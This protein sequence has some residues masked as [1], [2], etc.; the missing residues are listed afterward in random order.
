[1]LVLTAE[2]PPITSEAFYAPF[3]SYGRAADVV[4]S[5]F[6]EAGYD[7]RIEFHS[8][9]DDAYTDAKDEKADAAFPYYRTDWRE[10]DMVF[11][12][13]LLE[14][15]EVIFYNKRRAP[16]LDQ[17]DS[18]Q[19]LK[20]V[21]EEHHRHFRRSARFVEGYCY[22][23]DIAAAFGR[24]CKT[25]TEDPDPRDL[26]P[27]V[28]AF[29]ALLDDQN[30]LMLPA[31]RE[32]G[33]RILQTWF[34]AEARERIEVIPGLQ[35]R[36]PVYLVARDG[37]AGEKLIDGFNRGLERLRLSGQ[38]RELAN[39]PLPE[40][41]VLR[42]VRLSDPGTFPLVVARKEKG[43]AETI[44]LPRGTLAEVVQWS[45]NFLIPERTTLQEQL[46]R[47][48]RVMIMNGPQRGQLLW[49]KNV[50]IELQ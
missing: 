13:P 45:G 42:T 29:K 16:P 24:D 36:R 1:V 28:D 49:V 23:P 31:A 5:A 10:H 15:T 34:T 17:I 7:T 35:W 19:R 50:F 39:A 30:V 25:R 14:V 40:E 21:L 20:E 46:N 38:Y 32:V 33:E 41:S 48:S 26:P 2:W 9:F 37:A 3:M 6:D 8:S 47:M 22:N 44:V 11:S 4:V 27:G 18:L 43:A 12:D